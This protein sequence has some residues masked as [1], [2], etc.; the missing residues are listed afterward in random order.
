[1][2]RQQSI[3]PRSLFQKALGKSFRLIRKERAETQSE[4]ADHAGIH[5]THYGRIERGRGNPTFEIQVQ[6]VLALETSFARV[7]EL[8]DKF[9]KE[10]TR[11][12]SAG[13]P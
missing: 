11:E 6:I 3:P 9:L 5:L 10:Q 1:V 8:V 4:V 2:P 12:S 7:G 13:S